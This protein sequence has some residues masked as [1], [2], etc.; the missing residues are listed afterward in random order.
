MMQQMN[1]LVQNTTCSPPTFARCVVR[2]FIF[3][4]NDVNF[5]PNFG[6]K[7]NGMILLQLS[8][9]EFYLY[10]TVSTALIHLIKPGLIM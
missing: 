10:P 2:A 9:V 7:F 4:A 8:I 3:G 1:L 5:W 6:P